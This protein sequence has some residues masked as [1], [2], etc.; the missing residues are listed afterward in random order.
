MS[1]F[2]QS[3]CVKGARLGCRLEAQ[4]RPQK[5][6]GRTT[7]TLRKIPLIRCTSIKIFCFRCV[8]RSAITY[9]R[10]GDDDRLEDLQHVIPVVRTGGSDM[11]RCFPNL[12]RCA[13]S[14]IWTLPTTFSTA[15]PNAR[16]CPAHGRNGVNKS[17]NLSS[18]E[19][20]VPV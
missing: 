6:P 12:V 7:P 17:H 2:A 16:K 13:R 3:N 18:R 11:L 5:G 4:K 20:S 14:I 8:S 15:C 1:R 10:I 9:R 19:T